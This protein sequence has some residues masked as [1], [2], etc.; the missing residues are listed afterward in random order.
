ML[1]SNKKN[2]SV[3][4]KKLKKLRTDYKNIYDKIEPNS[5]MTHQSFRN[6]FLLLTLSKRIYNLERRIGK[7]SLLNKEIEEEKK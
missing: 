2:V 3:L 1:N 5:I 7:R 4:Q 6:H